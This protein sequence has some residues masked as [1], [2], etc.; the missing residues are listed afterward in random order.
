MPVRADRMT[1]VELERQLRILYVAHQDTAVEPHTLKDCDWCD[2]RMAQVMKLVDT[3]VMDL[4]EDHGKA[5]L[6]TSEQVQR[7][8]GLKSPDHARV[9]MS[10]WCIDAIYRS[11]GR[12][13]GQ[14]RAYYPAR[15][16]V[17]EARSRSVLPRRC[18]GS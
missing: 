10:R 18:K 6:W 14:K 7:Y 12:G 16:V 15:H 2:T 13:G 4:P 17:T 5:F 11:T 9:T 8:L 1:R 3:Y